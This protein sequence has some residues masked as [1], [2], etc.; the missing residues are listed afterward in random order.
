MAGRSTGAG[1]RR[2][3]RRERRRRASARRPGR[4]RRHLVA[5]SACGSCLAGVAAASGALAR[6]PVGPWRGEQRERVRLV[7]PWPGGRRDRVR[8]ADVAA[9]DQ[10][11]GSGR[12]RTTAGRCGRWRTTTG[13]SGRRTTASAGAG[14]GG[15]RRALARGPAVPWAVAADHCRR[16]WAADHVWAAA[17]HGRQ[18]GRRRLGWREPRAAGARASG[19]SAVACGSG[20]RPSRRRLGSFLKF[21]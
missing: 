7:G 17:D 8:P 2:R 9:A 12:G 20:I 3:G 11:G 1:P 15:P 18:L 10:G 5:A 4:R 13:G 21:F 14:A 16:I 6:Q 19:V